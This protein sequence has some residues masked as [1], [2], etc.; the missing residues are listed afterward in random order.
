MKPVNGV[1]A[2]GGAGEEDRKY[3]KAGGSK[4]APPPQFQKLNPDSEK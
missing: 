2:E 1:G 3:W 4:P